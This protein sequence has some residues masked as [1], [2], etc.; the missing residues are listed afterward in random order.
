MATKSNQSSK[1]Q[2]AN[3]TT[4]TKHKS[5]ALDIAKKFETP[6][7]FLTIA[8]KYSGKTHLLKWMIYKIAMAGKFDYGM[9]VSGTAET[10][11]WNIVP[12]RQ[13]FSTWGEGK[14]VIEKLIASQKK[15][16]AEKSKLPNV[17]IVLDDII[18]VIPTNDNLMSRLATSARHWKITLFVCIQS[19]KKIPPIFRINAEYIFVFRQID[20]TQV[21]TIYD[22]FGGLF[23]S[24]EEFS[25]YLKE[26]VKNYTALFINTK[27]QNNEKKDMFG[28]IKAPPD[29]PPFFIGKQ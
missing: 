13:I 17:F 14:P 15:F 21:G 7:L 19:A 8:K 23:G 26:Y 29:V 5:V 27:T 10:G 22:E 2:K 16:L 9:V 12:G 11:E 1:L 3:M 20:N 4:V 28:L 6:G 18:G 25:N 24:K